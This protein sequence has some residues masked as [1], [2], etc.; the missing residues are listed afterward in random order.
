M[1]HQ[2][3]R[4]TAY[5]EN[6]QNRAIRRQ[7]PLQLAWACT[8][9]KV[10]GITTDKAVVSLKN[11]FAAGMAYVA[12]SRVTSLEGIVIKNFDEDKIYCNEQISEA[13]SRMPPF[14]TPLNDSVL[15]QNSM[16][17]ILQSARIR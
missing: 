3:I 8:I 4:I 7:F 6:L 10:Q 5:E 12:L 14:L 1:Q 16:V 17:I 13:L 15:H 11:V 2:A 9:H